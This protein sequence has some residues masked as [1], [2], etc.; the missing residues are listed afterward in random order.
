MILIGLDQEFGSQCFKLPCWLLHRISR[1]I[2]GLKT[3]R[4]HLEKKWKKL[5][6]GKGGEDAA[7]AG[8][9]K[10]LIQDVAQKTNEVAGD[11]TTT[12]TVLACA[13]YLEGVKNV[14]AGCNPMDLRRGSQAAVDSVIQFLSAQTKAITTTSEIA[15]VAT[16][17]VNGDTHVGNLIAQ[18]MEKVGKDGVRRVWLMGLR[19]KG[20]WWWGPW[21]YGRGADLIEVCLWTLD[22]S[23]RPHVFI[24]DMQCL[25][26]MPPITSPKNLEKGSCR[27]LKR[28]MRRFEAKCS[29]HGIVMQRKTSQLFQCILGD[30]RIYILGQYKRIPRSIPNFSVKHLVN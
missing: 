19:K 10:S 3:A 23:W 25:L 17:S 21:R 26:S 2:S 18:A 8:K 11:G 7:K 28:R 1:N 5:D 15:Q 16:I 4:S 29:T 27:T 13:I 24:G 20:R 12:A 9:R 22:L 30:K 6:N 14:A